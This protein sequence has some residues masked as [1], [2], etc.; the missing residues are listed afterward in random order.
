[1]KGEGNM[2]IW[3]ICLVG[4]LTASLCSGC[5]S[6]GNQG[7]DVLTE[8]EKQEVSGAIADAKAEVQAAWQDAQGELREELEGTN[9]AEL[10]LEEDT[11]GRPRRLL[12][13]RA[14]G[15]TEEH[16]ITD[17]AGFGKSLSLED[18]KLSAETTED[19]RE[20]IV[21]TVQQK[22]SVG[23]LDG[24]EDEYRTLG[25]IIVFEDSDLVCVTASVLENTAGGITETLL[26]EK[27]NGW[28]SAVYQVP[29]EDLDIL[30]Q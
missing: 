24:R 19:L 2:K 5:V 4:C 25:S 21:Y 27:E 30:R 8:E 7:W 28:F 17:W 29:K 1:M 9:W 22:K 18:W 3:R 10:L 26:G 15:E 16:E 20:E 11:E 6:I 23:I 12:W 14:N 13:S